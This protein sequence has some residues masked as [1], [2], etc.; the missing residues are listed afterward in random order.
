[1]SALN[2]TSFFWSQAGQYE[3][4]PA[5]APP[6]GVVP[7]FTTPNDRAQVYSIICS[8]LLFIVYLFLCLRLYAKIYIQ[9]SPGIDDRE[10]P[11][12][13]LLMTTWG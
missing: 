1:M 13:F 8:I 2:A 7:D 3:N 9:R 4:T 12:S 10:A 5:L 11:I 6:A